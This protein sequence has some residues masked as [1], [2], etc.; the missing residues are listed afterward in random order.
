MNKSY[1]L[2]HGRTVR[3]EESTAHHWIGT[4]ASLVIL[5]LHEGSHSDPAHIVGTERA[6]SQL[7]RRGAP[8]QAMVVF[9]PNLSKAPSAEVRQAIVQAA[10]TFSKL[11]RAAGVVMG[12]GFLAA[13]HRAAMTGVLAMLRLSVAVRVVSSVG[14]ALEHLY[15]RAAAT[16][17]WAPLARFCE[18]RVA[19]G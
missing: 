19:E 16:A 12:Q 1:D 14:E 2:G 15:G 3:C 5:I 17:S 13:T 10:S 8:V 11:D 18:E 6:V 7:L 9:A 4:C